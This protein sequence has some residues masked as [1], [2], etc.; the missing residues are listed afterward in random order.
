VIGPAGDA[1]GA[2]ADALVIGPAGKQGVARTR[3]LRDSTAYGRSVDAETTLPRL[4]RALSRHLATEPADMGFGL[5]RLCSAAAEEIERLTAA[6]DE[7]AAQSVTTQRLKHLEAEV[8]RLQAGEA[9][10]A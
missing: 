1:P 7:T 4:L 8:L 10:R 5:P 2:I 9:P 6:I 3:F